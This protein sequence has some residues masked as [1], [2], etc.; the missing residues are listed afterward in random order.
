MQKRERQLGMLLSIILFVLALQISSIA[1][2]PTS[3]PATELNAVTDIY[4]DVEVTEYYRWLENFEDPVVKEWNTNQNLYSR[5]ILDTV[6]NREGIKR[7]LSELMGHV[8][9]SYYSFT[10]LDN[11]V[12][13]KK[14]QPPAQHSYLIS[15]SSLNNPETEKTLVDVNELDKE[16]FTSI[17]F[18]VPSPDGKLVAVSMSKKGSEQGSVSIYNVETGEPLVDLVPRVN[19][20]T[21]GGDVAWKNDNSGFYYTRYPHKGERDDVDLSFYQQVYYHQMGT[22]YNDDRYITGEQFPRIAEIQLEMS[23]DGTLMIVTV[24]NGD[25]GEFEH[26]LVDENENVTQFTQLEDLI[27]EAT[28]GADKSIYCLSHK[29][30]P[31]GQI[32]KMNP[33]NYDIANAELLVKESDVAIQQIAV[34]ESKLYIRDMIGGPGQ[35]RCWDMA[36]G[37]TKIIPTK[38]ISSVGG[39]KLL[40]DDQ[41]FY[42]NSSYIDPSAWYIYNPA[43]GETK[44]TT[45]YQTSAAD[46]S[47]I[48]VIRDFATSKDGTKVPV[49]IIRRKDTELNGQNPTIL[50]AYG[51]Y[52]ICLSP[53]FNSIRRLWFDQGGVYVIANIRGGGEYGEKWHCEGNLTK[54][55]NVFDDFAA[56]AQ[57]LIDQKYTSPSLLTIIGGSNGGLLMGAAL[58]QHPELYRAVV[59]S[60][61]IYDMLRVELDPNGEFNITEFGTVKN[62]DH[63]KALYAYSPIHNVKKDTEYP[64]VIFLT[65]DHDGRVNPMQSRKMT[66]ALQAA[67]ASGNPILLRTSSKTGHGGGA[68]DLRIERET[69]IFSFIFSQLKIDFKYDQ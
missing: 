38:E 63:F 9:P 4:H 10:V 67:T 66:A 49:N 25:G 54:K 35:I 20:P 48:E 50:Y 29:D 11:I 52:G 14:Y 36:D 17:D 2:E 37:S 6:S 31:M 53:S 16:H 27:P 19:G 8:S 69:D 57:Y 40:D 47:D 45:F 24:A 22:D 58:T 21:A 41:L 62:P 64:S 56:S 39:L 43:S 28:F 1:A 23:E 3:P 7:Q 12:F 51:G 60:V 13:A 32:L 5:S 68:L 18:Y 30:T 26:F 15:M 33:G 46:F 61:G 55:Q 59:A 44:R 65:G 34:G 42:R